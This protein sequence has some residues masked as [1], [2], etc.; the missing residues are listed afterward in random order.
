[1]N[2]AREWVLPERQYRPTGTI[3]T[4]ESDYRQSSCSN[5][6]LI[7]GPDIARRDAAQVTCGLRGNLP[8]PDHRIIQIN[9]IPWC[10][11]SSGIDRRIAGRLT[12]CYQPHNR[13]HRMDGAAE[14]GI[15]GPDC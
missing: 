11:S 1:M 7:K 10:K 3:D 8:R 6:L 13:Q 5:P 14:P 2:T 12:P 9:L 4:V 15:E